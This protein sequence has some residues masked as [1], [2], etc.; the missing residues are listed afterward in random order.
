MLR[1]ATDI[2]R[3][4]GGLKLGPVEITRVEDYQGPGLK[5]TGMFPDF[6][7]EMWQAQKDWLVPAFYD[8]QEDRIRTSIHSWLVRTPHH[9]ILIDS[10][11]GN[12]KER[13]VDPRF[14]MRNEPWLERLARAGARPEDVD[15]VM[16]THFHA[17]HVGWNTR[18]EN[19]RWVPTFPNAKYL[20]TKKE[21][22]RWDERR[23]EHVPCQSERFIF[24]DSILPVVEAG[25]M[26]LVDEGYTLD[27][28]MTVEAAY[29]HTPGHIKIRLRADG[30]HALFCGDVIHHPVQLPYPKVYS[31]FDDD[32]VQA[33]QT[34]LDVLDDC[35]AHGI[36][37][38]PTH[39]A[40]PYLCRIESVG[41]AIEPSYMPLWHR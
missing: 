34:R 14:H 10:C 36:L 33:L 3:R 31:I 11:I 32:P 22:D 2:N 24:A 17:D 16:C 8:P 25:Q 27:D 26:E 39:F 37:L 28:A 13:P 4:G 9:T 35:A 5:S 23:P 6:R 15:F 38:L 1:P 18:L 20:F 19:G 29:G 41:T 40:D 7:P 21:F 30:G 12:H